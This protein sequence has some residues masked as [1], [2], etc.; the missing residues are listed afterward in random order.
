MNVRNLWDRLRETFWLVPTIVLAM[1]VV[2]SILLINIDGRGPTAWMERWPRLFGSGAA[3]ARG[4][5]STIAGSMMTVVG[6][7][8]SMTLVTLA[9][10]SSQYSSPALVRMAAADGLVVRLERGVGDFVIRDASIASIASIASSPSIGTVTAPTVPMGRAEHAAV[11]DAF[12]IARHRTVDQDYAF[13]I[14]QIVD[15]GLRALSPGINDTTTAIMCVDYLSAIGRCL[16]VRPMPGAYHCEAGALRVIEVATTF[17]GAIDE[18]FDQ[19]RESSAGNVA[20]MLRMLDAC[21][22]IADATS[23]RA[24]RRAR[25][26]Q[27]R[28]FPIVRAIMV[29]ARP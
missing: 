6:V 22:T 19:L 11:E 16:A 10:A 14:R 5:L 21:A 8:F 7:T 12:S 3:G 2:A 15:V 13:G 26:H 25:R 9:L 29:S 24:R 20:V 27:E 23:D 1:S 28:N 4:M 18:A 17:T